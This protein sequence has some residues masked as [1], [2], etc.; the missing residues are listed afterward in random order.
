MVTP[1]DPGDVTRIGRY[2]L[3]GLLGS[4][5]MGRVL[6]GAGPDG[7]LV[8][9]K[10]IHPHLV[11]EGD[12]RARFRREVQISARVSGAFTA[13]V[14]DFEIDSEF[15]WLASVF[16]PGLSLDRAVTEYGPMPEEQLLTL[17]VGL[18]AA[19]QAIH[20]V[21]LV[22]RDLK[23]A[24]VILAEDG[25][26]VI[27]FGI[28]R[29]VDERSELTGTGSII[30]SPAY[31]SPEQAQSE[32]LTAASDIFSFG[33]VL[34][35][36]A[37]G[38]SPFAGS[39][40]PETL[41]RILHAE[42]DL[43]TLSPTVRRLVEPCLH[44][45]PGLRPT[46]ALLLDHLGPQPARAQ[47]WT[48]NVHEAIRRSAELAASAADPEATLVAGAVENSGQ[49]QAESA[50]DDPAAAGERRKLRRSIGWSTALAAL[51][52]LVITAG[53]VVSNRDEPAATM[54]PPPGMT[55]TALR[56][57]DVCA[58]LDDPVV[59]GPGTW[60]RPP[61]SEQWG[62]CT[63][64][65]G[66]HRL[67][68]AVERTDGFHA[69]GPA[70]GGVLISDA[71]DRGEDSCTRGLRP[72]GTDPQFGVTIR[73]SGGTPRNRCDLASRFAARIASR[74]TTASPL[75]PDIRRS[76][77]GHDPC[78]LVTNETIDTRIGKQ[79]DGS[80][81]ALHSC[82]WNGIY[83]LTVDLAQGKVPD[84]GSRPIGLDG[85]LPD[86]KIYVTESELNSP[87]CTRM[88]VYRI[89]SGGRAEMVTVR[90]ENPA[91]S[92]V[93]G[94]RCIIAQEI[95]QDIMANLPEVK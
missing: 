87:S 78:S 28:A 36:A 95:V 34:V 19:L 47:P 33:V 94:I 13:A 3:L 52:A 82:V 85:F 70:T 40:V 66:D 86:E 57:M 31:M 10:Q 2:R 75:L 55:L 89:V 49:P 45:D 12:F 67:D 9:I 6:L 65:D 5:G 35:M 16:V 90:V 73:I 53:I 71:A 41:Y 38:R 23:P 4:G 93:A 29:A 92:A 44:K 50:F 79:V 42:P 39:T 81:V 68:I 46:T 25:P 24:N 54:P 8:A 18:A 74:I 72:A 30:G 32:T 69:S 80:A 43:R 26:R 83:T 61:A 17:A 64:Q 14:V 1:L 77:A 7:R 63:A 88:G 60:T 91:E 51:L 22:H 62:T 76:L 48:R 15:P 59:S 37:A 84:T 27:D 56:S 20:R 11:A 58:L 21:G